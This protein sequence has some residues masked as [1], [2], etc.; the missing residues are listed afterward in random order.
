[1]DKFQKVSYFAIWC[2]YNPK[3]ILAFV[4]FSN[5]PSYIC[6]LYDTHCNIYFFLFSS[7]PIFSSPLCQVMG[8][9]NPGGVPHQPQGDFSLSP[10]TGSLEPSAG[11]AASCH[12]SQRLESLSGLASMPSL[13]SSQSYCPPSYSSPAYS[14]DHMAPYQYSQYGQ[15][16]VNTTTVCWCVCV[17]L[18]LHSD[19]CSA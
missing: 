17:C 5:M 16:K 3:I 8:L 10:L 13:P 15:S 12:S 2:Q 7:L 11:M 18:C 19:L 14:V 4:D 6:V 1:M 9:L